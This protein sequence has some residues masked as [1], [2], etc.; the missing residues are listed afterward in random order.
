MENK[1]FDYSQI[2]KKAIKQETNKDGIDEATKQKGKKRTKK[3]SQ[4][5][6]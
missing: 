4:M 5:K 1:T 6:M 2:L 3:E